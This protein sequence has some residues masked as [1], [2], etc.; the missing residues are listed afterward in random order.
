[1]KLTTILLIILIPAMLHPAEFRPDPVREHIERYGR[2]IDPAYSAGHKYKNLQLK[3][4]N[5]EPRGNK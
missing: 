1:M 3:K 4:K 5:F 2:G